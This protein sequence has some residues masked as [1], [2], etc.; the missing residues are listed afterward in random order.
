MSAR[1]DIW[2]DD[3]L[4]FPRVES[5]LKNEV[6]RRK[7]LI[8]TLMNDV[9]VKTQNN[10]ELKLKK[11]D[12]SINLNRFLN[13]NPKYR[14]IG[15]N[16]PPLNSLLEPVLVANIKHNSSKSISKITIEKLCRVNNPCPRFK[17]N[18]RAFNDNE[19]RRVYSLGIE[20]EEPEEEEE[21]KQ[22]EE[23]EEE[24]VPEIVSNEVEEE[25]EE[26]KHFLEDIHKK[27]NLV[28]PPI[29]PLPPIKEIPIIKQKIIEEEEEEERVVTPASDIL[30]ANLP[31]FA[32]DVQ[33]PFESGKT[34]EKSKLPGMLSR[35]PSVNIILPRYCFCLR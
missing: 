35:E 18:I 14:G 1:K 26:L 21:P 29:V 10:N 28:L 30:D 31:S 27:E 5:Y 16:R 9:K 32:D 11:Y 20:E 19:F 24:K 33:Q 4:K 22:E 3:C 17:R 23:E 15:R 34:E 25:E 13:T 8:G 7:A 6:V 12:R 2:G